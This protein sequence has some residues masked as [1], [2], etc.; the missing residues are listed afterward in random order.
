M[1]KRLSP[2]VSSSFFALTMLG[3][4]GVA[5]AQAAPHALLASPEIYKVI[6]ENAQYRV[7]EVTWK[8]GQR[9]QVHSHPASAVYYPMDCTLRGFESSGDVIGSRLN[10]AGSA[11]VQQP[12]PAHAVEN[13]GNADCRLIMFEPK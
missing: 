9:D 13:I 8:P 4:T 12:I 7:I 6:A 1:L 11:I 5:V 10:R 3:T 2:F